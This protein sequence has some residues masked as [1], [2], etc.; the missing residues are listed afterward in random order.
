MDNLDQTTLQEA[1]RIREIIQAHPLPPGVHDFRIEFGEDSTGDPAFT[2]WLIV[3]ENDDETDEAE[4][5]ASF[6]FVRD[7]KSAIRR[8]GLRHWV[9]VRFGLLE[10]ATNHA[11][12]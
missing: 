5:A 2:V 8:A 4:M 3:S 12:I 7:I 1:A 11:L 6:D 10:D 9:Y